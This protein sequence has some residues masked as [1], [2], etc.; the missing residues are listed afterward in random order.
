MRFTLLDRS[1]VLISIKPAKVMCNVA[2]KSKVVWISFA[3]FDFKL[4]GPKK[5]LLE[6]YDLLAD[7]MD[8]AVKAG[9]Y[10]VCLHLGYYQVFIDR[11]IN[12][13]NMFFC[14]EPAPECYVLRTNAPN[15]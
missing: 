9:G 5:E 12:E 13:D 11:L 15:V 3:P 6:K 7:T 8:S 10:N 2:E 4:T 14:W 1:N